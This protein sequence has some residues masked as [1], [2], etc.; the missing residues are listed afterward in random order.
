ME[1]E[2]VIVRRTIGAKKDEWFL[3]RKHAKKSE[4]F[5]M[6]ETAG[7]SSS[8]PYYIVQQG[9]VKKLSQ[10]RD[11]ERLKLLKEVAG[12]G[13]YESRREE[14]LNILTDTD[15]KR[16][17]IDE[18]LAHIES[19]IDELGEERAELDAWQQLDRHRRA[20]EYSLYDKERDEIKRRLETLTSSAEDGAADSAVHQRQAVEARAALATLRSQMDAL[21]DELRTNTSTQAEIRAA[22]PS[23]TRVRVQ[24]ESRVAELG[25]H[26]AA[27]DEAQKL[28]QVELAQLRSQA[29][30]VQSQ[31]EATLQ[32]AAAAALTAARAAQ[33]ALERA[34]ARVQM[35]H[36]RG[37]AGARRAFASKAERDNWIRAESTAL[38]EE[39]R[40]LQAAAQEAEQANASALRRAESA[41]QAAIEADTACAKARQAVAGAAK[42][43]A[44]LRERL[45]GKVAAMMRAQSAFTAVGNEESA[46]TDE[47]A[48]A[49]RKIAAAMP[50]SVRKGV[51]ELQRLVAEEGWQGIHGMLLDVVTPEH[52]RFHTALEVS[53]RSQ[54]FNVVVDDEEVAAKAIA[55]LHTTRRGRVTLMPLNRLT[56]AAVRYPENTDD[57]VPLVDKLQ[58]DPMYRPAVHTVWGR[59]LLCRDLDVAVQY[60]ASA[61]LPCVTLHGDEV[62]QRG[63][64]YGGHVDTTRSHFAA[65]SE[66]RAAQE[67]HAACVSRAADARARMQEE[68][69]ASTDLRGR[70]AAAEEAAQ[71]ATSA[72]SAQSHRVQAARA[73][74]REARD[75]AAK[76]EQRAGSLRAQAET[77]LARAETLDADLG[78]PLETSEED[79]ASALA[80]AEAALQAARTTS[81]ETDA[82]LDVAQRAV[83]QAS[84]ELRENLERRMA[85]VE[86]RL[87]SLVEPADGAGESSTADRQRELHQAQ[88][89]LASAQAQEQRLQEAAQAASDAGDQARARQAELSDQADVLRVAL[90]EHEEALATE[91]RDM[92]SMIEKRG[93]ALRKRED[94]MRRI[95]DLGAVP[96]AE[97]AEY[98]SYSKKELLKALDGTR[99]ELQQFA[100]VNQKALD[101]YTLFTEQRAT[102]VERKVELDRGA[103][104]IHTLVEHLDEQKDEAILRTFRM[105]S[106]EFKR[107]FGELVPRGSGKLVMQRRDAAGAGEF[108]L[109]DDEEFEVAR[110]ALEEGGQPGPAAAAAA[111]SAARASTRQRLAQRVDNFR[112]V[113]VQV[114]FA[115]GMDTKDMMQLSGGQQSLVA[116][117][118]IFAIQRCDPAPFYVFDEVDAALDESHRAAVAALVHRQAHDEANPAQ[119]IV[120][121]FRPE[122]AELADTWHGVS[123][124]HGMSLVHPQSRAEALA[125][126]AQLQEEGGDDGAAAHATDTAHKRARPA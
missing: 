51:E 105:V 3:N 124:N 19:R 28:L 5:Q 61:Q 23:A 65:L 83:A 99:A 70:L 104:R 91:E 101:Q 27:D 41:D 95:R 125:F 45:K 97:L 33:Q 69:T 53:A 9:R 109:S 106:T 87:E 66:L 72:V 57:C 110:A 113:A 31:L 68:E 117:A 44:D 26:V 18:V 15:T 43:A 36:A 62:A 82:A 67:R 39:S 7:F 13:V 29:A 47:L 86:S 71:Q 10:M 58:Y 2:E 115:A 111:V 126:I 21:A 32:P 98:A 38:R 88:T 80:S 118:L 24:A 77:Q 55:H 108:E 119:F 114:S 76:S 46:C 64:M 35:L 12:T 81:T 93:I 84:A 103:E 34:N 92:E 120:S 78:T 54:L 74:A 52:P 122:V 42:E 96:G 48:R 1:Q 123:Y 6:L 17:K 4:V 85:E 112:G 63:A 107:V 102:L 79:S 59:V 75:E 8:N 56:P 60:A 14:A 37:S 89:E 25:A 50:A 40:K 100:H 20:I 30:E 22:L 90:A 121:T 116:L 94:V 16:E 11:A 49:K 73:E